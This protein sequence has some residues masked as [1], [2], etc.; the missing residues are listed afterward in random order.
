MKFKIKGLNK[1]MK[2]LEKAG[3]EYAK[4]ELKSAPVEVTCLKC[5]EKLISTDKIASC[6]NCASTFEI[7]RNIHWIS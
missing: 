3:L 5:Q 6:P 4:Q 2:Q 1:A 7:I